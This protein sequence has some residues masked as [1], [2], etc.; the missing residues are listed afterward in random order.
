MI[1]IR[2]VPE[3]VHARLKEKAETA[4]MNLS[5]FLKREVT[6][7]AEERSIEEVLAPMK[8]R[9]LKADTDQIVRD[10]RAARDSR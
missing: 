5:D 10:I 1:Q 8:A 6:R 3:D 7:I 9:G 4:G 2:N